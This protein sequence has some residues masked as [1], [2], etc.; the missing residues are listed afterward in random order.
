MGGETGTQEVT[1]P[2]SSIE[3]T[4]ESPARP[5]PRAWVESQQAHEGVRGPTEEAACLGGPAHAQSQVQAAAVLHRVR[6][7]QAL[8]LR[9]GKRAGVTS[10]LLLLCPPTPPPPHVQHAARSGAPVADHA[11][12]EEVAG[13]AHDVPHRARR[14]AGELLRRDGAVECEQG[15]LGALA[16]VRRHLRRDDEARRGGEDLQ[17]HVLLLRREVEQAR[18]DRKR[19]VGGAPARADCRVAERERM[20]CQAAERNS[21]VRHLRDCDRLRAFVV[22]AV[23]LQH[24][25][26]SFGAYS[27]PCIARNRTTRNKGF[28]FVM[29]R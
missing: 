23:D 26:V 11:R 9:R 29:P 13:R 1:P 22:L 6:V 25:T 19:P 15:C 14:D 12:D 8:Q 3:G 18:R 28:F 16:L 4:Q 21:R 2:R 17:D 7:Q 27:G 5:S 10:R 20:A 24:H